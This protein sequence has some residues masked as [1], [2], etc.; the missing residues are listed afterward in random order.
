MQ[1]EVFNFLVDQVNLEE[2]DA[3]SYCQEFIKEGFDS[4]E[5]LEGLTLDDIYPSIIS[6]RGHARD[7]I[8]KLNELKA[9]PTSD[10]SST[11]SHVPLSM[12]SLSIKR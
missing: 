9:S 11:F 7:F 12:D 2:E 4:M 6:R 5:R 1:S 3:L 8:R 10:S